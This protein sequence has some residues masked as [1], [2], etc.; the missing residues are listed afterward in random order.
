MYKIIA[1]L[2]FYCV[3]FL[4]LS[5][6][7]EFYTLPADLL[8][9]ADAVVR[10]ERQEFEVQSIGKGTEK[11]YKSITIL[12]Q[13]GSRHATLAVSYSKLNKL[14][15]IKAA[16]Y[17]KFGKQIRKVKASEFQ[18]Y[19]ASAF[20]GSFFEDVR[21]KA[22]DL[23]YTDYPYT[24]EFEYEILNDGLLFYPVWQP[25]PS[26][27]L[28]VQASKF[29]I[30]L[31]AAT[32]FRFK[33]FNFSKEPSIQRETDKKRYI[34][35][36]TAL[37]AY[38]S[39]PYVQENYDDQPLIFTAPHNFEIEGYSGDMSSWE[40]F[41]KFIAKLNEGTR[42]LPETSIA[43]IKSLVADCQD[44][45]CKISKL[46]EYLQANTRYVS[47]QLGIGGWRPMTAKDV[48]TY[49][50]G[51]CKALSN[52]FCAMLEVVDIQG[53]YTLIRAGHDATPILNDFPSS[54]FN[55]VIV[56]VPQGQDTIWVECTSQTA[57]LGYCGSFTGNREALLITPEGGKLVHT[58]S[59]SMQDNLQERFTQLK[60]EATGNA[61]A[62]ITSQYHGL[63]QEYASHLSEMPEQKRRDE[64]YES[65][66]LKNFEILENTYQRNKDRL[67]SV[68]E[69]LRLRLPAYAGRSG[70]RLFISPNLLSQWKRI[71]PNDSLRLRNIQFSSFPYLDVDTVQIQIPENFGIEHLPEA[72]QVTSVFGAY[73]AGFEKQNNQILFYR[74]LELNAD[75]HSREQ[76]SQL[77][78]FCKKINK[79]DS[80]R[81]VLIQQDP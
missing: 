15:D 40:S 8:K 76:Y 78:D 71:P 59:Q 4:P 2:L 66:G 1:I 81:L 28:A 70:K 50:Y 34:W 52:Y 57:A 10:E 5:A 41:G 47:I 37:P 54:Q 79:A 17:D 75:V 27:A 24:V 64:L 62:T 23:S 18:D 80:R 31:P 16:L 22:I 29:E 43:K 39:E 38:D 67:P 14:K 3:M 11:H 9:G 26:P 46:Y 25:Q 69:T 12:N 36:A 72:V 60:V 21:I 68:A 13:A 44:N 30:V 77:V 32:E 55:H 74:R 49:K 65:M 6:Q 20:S 63:Q 58:P 61:E 7:F 73:E 35:Q 53:F 45:Y 56:S 51:D 48:D 19:S 42:S 33:T